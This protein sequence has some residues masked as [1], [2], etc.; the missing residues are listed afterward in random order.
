M[1]IIRFASGKPEHWATPG[2]VQS[3]RFASVVSAPARQ[4]TQYLDIACY[5]GEAAFKRVVFS[6]KH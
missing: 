5:Y 6:F 2:F 1:D 4:T 3:R